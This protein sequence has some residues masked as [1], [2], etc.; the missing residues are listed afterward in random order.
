MFKAIGIE[1]TEEKGRRL[2]ELLRECIRIFR[3]DD[4]RGRG[5]ASGAWQ[6]YKNSHMVKDK[7]VKD[8]HAT[9]SIWNG[10]LFAGKHK[11][12]NERSRSMGG[13]I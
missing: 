2:K 7:I 4:G 12:E 9:I 1:R 10:I 13:A 11:S 3:S 5:N 6:V 8:K